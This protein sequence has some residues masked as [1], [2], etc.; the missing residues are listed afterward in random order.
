[1]KKIF[2]IALI[3]SLLL[4]GCQNE[5]ID[6]TTLPIET[7]E[8]D[9]QDG[10]NAN[11]NMPYRFT[12]KYNIY[13][14][15]EDYGFTLLSI[16]GIERSEGVLLRGMEAVVDVHITNLTNDSVELKGEK[17]VGISVKLVCKTYD[18]S[19]QRNIDEYIINRTHYIVSGDVSSIY[20]W[21]PGETIP[22]SFYYFTIPGHAIPGSYS[23]ECSYMGSTVV[24]ED[25]FTL[26]EDAF[27]LDLRGF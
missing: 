23:L 14:E 19:L 6:D 18:E 2:A 12:R 26:A 24:F 8:P 5:D 4:V 25:V 15:T 9:T 17:S 21:A 7:S 1:M 10:E 11:Q 27:P 20:E 16:G 13:K 3:L 22:T